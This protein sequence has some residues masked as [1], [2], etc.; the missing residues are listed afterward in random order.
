MIKLINIV[1]N[2]AVERLVTLI[3]WSDLFKGVAERIPLDRL[4][5]TIN[6]NLNYSTLANT[7]DLHM[8][9]RNL[10]YDD[11]AKHLDYET[12]VESFPGGFDYE[13]VARNIDA[14]E[15]AEQ[16]SFSDKQCRTM[17]KEFDYG[18]LNATFSS[19]DFLEIA[20]AIDYRD[21]DYSKIPGVNPAEVVKKVTEAIIDELD[22]TVFARQVGATFREDAY[23]QVTAMVKADVDAHLASLGI[24]KD[25]PA[26]E[27]NYREMV[28]RDEVMRVMRT[29]AMCATMHDLATDAVNAYISAEKAAQVDALT[30]DL[31][32]TA[33][34]KAVVESVIDDASKGNPGL[35]NQ[36]L[37]RAAAML[38]DRAVAAAERGE[39][40]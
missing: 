25:G 16:F 33:K 23:R 17:M 28:I 1:V 24:T 30:N 19:N 10:D 27:K 35:L 5:M 22:M 29:P 12:L 38:L 36:L 20:R 21:L 8:V 15:L 7:V 32:R 26:V 40:S 11:L 18:R 6:D 39:V 2:R 4:A 37:D 13:Q 14:R 31:F 34:P 9:T 3:G